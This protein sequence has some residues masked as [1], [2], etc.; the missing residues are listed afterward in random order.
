MFITETSKR[1]KGIVGKL[2]NIS[3]RY[4][5]V[6]IASKIRALFQVTRSY[7]KIPATLP[8]EI[9]SGLTASNSARSALMIN[10]NLDSLGNKAIRR[11]TK[12]I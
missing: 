3:I 8:T 5:I 10:S 9:F 7:S 12:V 1:D 11:R 4:N 6:Q 2:E